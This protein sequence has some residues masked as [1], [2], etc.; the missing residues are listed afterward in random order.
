MMLTCTEHSSVPIR[1]LT[2]HLYV[3]EA[4]SVAFLRLMVPPTG[5]VHRSKQILHFNW[6]I[7]QSWQFI[8]IVRINKIM[9]IQGSWVKRNLPSTARG[10]SSL[11]PVVLSQMYCSGCVPSTELHLNIISFPAWVWPSALHLGLEGRTV[12]EETGRSDH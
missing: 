12:E 6:G 3:P 5:S 7:W 9:K 4:V 10:G 11:L 1:F 2:M 8:K